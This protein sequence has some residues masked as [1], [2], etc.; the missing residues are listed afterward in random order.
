VGGDDG[1]MGTAEVEVAVGVELVVVGDE[2]GG[3]EAIIVNGLW[4]GWS[5]DPGGLGDGP[6]EVAVELATGRDV[7]GAGLGLLPKPPGVVEGLNVSGPVFEAAGFDA[8]DE[9]GAEVGF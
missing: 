4:T 6:L 8:G 7:V 1:G 3:D 5:G 2:G 9:A